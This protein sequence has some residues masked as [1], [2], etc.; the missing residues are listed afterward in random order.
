MS[1]LLALLN[2]LLHALPDAA[3]IGALLSIFIKPDKKIFSFPANQTLGLTVFVL[4]LATMVGNSL[5]ESAQ[6]RERIV[7]VERNIAFLIAGASLS[8]DQIHDRFFKANLYEIEEALEDM[9]IGG[10]V[11]TDIQDAMIMGR[12]NIPVRVRVFTLLTS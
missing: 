11:Q 12:V 5:Y 1:V 6:H 10:S 4:I 3:A 2:A 9:M 8:V 7:Y